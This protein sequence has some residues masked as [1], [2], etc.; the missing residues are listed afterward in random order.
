MAK[1]GRALASCV[2]LFMLIVYSHNTYAAEHAYH[3]GSKALIF[4]IKDLN[5]RAIEGA[6][7][8]YKQHISDKSALRLGLNVG[9]LSIDNDYESKVN[10]IQ[11]ETGERKSETNNT[12]STN[13]LSIHLVYLRTNGNAKTV[14]LYYGLGPAAV[15]RKIKDKTYY[16]GRSRISSDKETYKSAGLLGILGI[17]WFVRKEISLVAEYS[18]SAMFYKEKGEDTSYNPGIQIER[19][20]K[21]TSAFNMDAKD[22]KLGICLYF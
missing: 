5:L 6:L 9:R 3:K 17:E 18:L 7:L 13:E 15:Y 14:N 2:L 8:S 10:L 1:P 12:K 11:Q 19:T 20:S 22:V 21:K 16:D 4:Q